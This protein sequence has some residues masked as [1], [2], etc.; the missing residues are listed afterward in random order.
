MLCDRLTFRQ[1]YPTFRHGC[2]ANNSNNSDQKYQIQNPKLPREKSPKLKKKC[3]LENKLLLI[4]INFTPKNSHSC[5]KKWYT[6]F[7]RYCCPATLSPFGKHTPPFGTAAALTA[8][9]TAT[10]HT[11]SKIQNYQEKKNPKLK[12][13][14][15]YKKSKLQIIP[16]PP[17]PKLQDLR[18]HE[19][20]K[21]Y[22]G[23]ATRVYNGQATILRPSE[24]LP[25]WVTHFRPSVAEGMSR[26]CLCIDLEVLKVQD[27]SSHELDH[28]VN[29]TNQ[30]T[31]L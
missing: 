23:Q 13:T 17:H 2:R 15:I 27:A 10:K 24:R 19:I 20:Q 9:T 6:M 25:Q 21:F 5:L 7:S 31:I 8:V 11:K 29:K 4:S 14:Q 16:R 3:Y 1:A 28:S 26:H 22:N 30:N 18:C 12:K